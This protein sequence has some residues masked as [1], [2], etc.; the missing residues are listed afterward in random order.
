ML[1][2]KDIAPLAPWDNEL[3]KFIN[4]PRY[5][6]KSEK[7]FLSTLISDPFSVS[8]Q[9][10]T[11]VKY[12][13]D[14]RD[15]FDEFCKEKLREVRAAKKAAQE[16]GAT[17]VDVGL[18]FSASSLPTADIIPSLAT[19]TNSIPKSTLNKCHFNTNSFLRFQK[20]SFERS[21]VPRIW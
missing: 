3:P 9:S 15:L 11:A 10:T 16:A 1:S 19:A 2:E 4:D 18:C 13:K 20:I 7:Y 12:L 6:G 5:S 8:F 14:R 21:K 17:K